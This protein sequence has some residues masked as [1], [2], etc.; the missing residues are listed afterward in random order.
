MA[1]CLSASTSAR[2]RR[3]AGLHT[4]SLARALI[5]PTHARTRTHTTHAT[6][7]AQPSDTILVDHSVYVRALSALKAGGDFAE[8]GEPLDFQ[9]WDD[10]EFDGTT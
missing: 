6:P 10:V 7:H 1:S 2:T 3:C 5:N 9:R 4:L 8:Q